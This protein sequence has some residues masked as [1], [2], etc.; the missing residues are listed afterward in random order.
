MH[1]PFPLQCW[2]VIAKLRGYNNIAKGR[3]ETKGS[4][5]FQSVSRFLSE[6]V[7]PQ[8][9]KIILF[10]SKNFLK[11]RETKDRLFQPWVCK[12]SNL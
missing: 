5:I 8:A 10:D 3:E 9:C 2:D 6:I 11:L 4:K 7:D 1:I 12:T